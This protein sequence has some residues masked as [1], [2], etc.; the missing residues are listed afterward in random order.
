MP[1][2]YAKLTVKALYSKNSDYSEPKVTF[3]PD[4]YTLTPDEY[5]HFEMNCDD[6]GETFT[7]DMFTGGVTMVMIKNNDTAINVT[8]RFDTAD[9]VTV[10]I[11]IPPGG[12]F[13]TPDFLYTRNLML[14]SA[15]GTPECEVLI[16]GT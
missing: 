13:V 11:I 1:T 14:T 3:S 12:I 16:V 15:S 10:N 6:N 7:T 4:I 8:A 2:D 9:D 5:V